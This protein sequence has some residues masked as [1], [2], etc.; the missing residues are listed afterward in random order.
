[1][2]PW[3]SQPMKSCLQA[4]RTLRSGPSVR[5]TSR[6]LEK[7]WGLDLF[8]D[9]RSLSRVLG[10]GLKLW[11]CMSLRWKLT[12]VHIHLLLVLD[13]QRV[14]TGWHV[15]QNGIMNERSWTRESWVLFEWTFMN[16][17]ERSR[18]FMNN[19]NEYQWQK[20]HTFFKIHAFSNKFTYFS[21]HF[22]RFSKKLH[23]F[24]SFLADG[25]RRES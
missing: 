12:I 14:L 9:S 8:T 20:F 21:E 17:H 19:L 16:V 2:H 25:T 3:F 15:H 10:S 6:N 5:I 1:M 4:R 24:Q 11:S 18:K 7:V 23:V 13:I 22:T